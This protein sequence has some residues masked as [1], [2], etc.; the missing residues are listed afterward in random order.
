MEV[1]FERSKHPTFVQVVFFIKFRAQQ[2][3]SEGSWTR[4][5]VELP[6]HAKL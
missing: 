6:P 3:I 5:R 2:V 1:K 4:W